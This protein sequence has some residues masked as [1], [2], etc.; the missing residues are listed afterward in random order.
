[1]HLVLTSCRCVCWALV[2]GDVPDAYAVCG[3]TSHA[4]VFTLACVQA[5]LEAV[6]RL[7]CVYWWVSVLSSTRPA[8]PSVSKLEVLRAQVVMTGS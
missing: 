4:A 8:E 1:M 5:L 7:W 3:M 6:G 2:E